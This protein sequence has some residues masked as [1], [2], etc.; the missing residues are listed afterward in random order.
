MGAFY[1]RCTSSADAVDK[2]DKLKCGNAFDESVGEIIS[3]RPPAFSL[4]MLNFQ[5][6]EML[7]NKTKR[8]SKDLANV[9]REMVEVYA[10][11]CKLC[12]ASLQAGWAA[13]SHTKNDSSALV[14]KLHVKH[15]EWTRR[16]AIAGQHHSRR[17][18]TLVVA[19][20][21]DLQNCCDVCSPRSCRHISNYL[22]F[23]SLQGRH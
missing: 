3:F 9:E 18:R 6:E 22:R 2:E 14:V 23:W 17:H 5:K 20:F 16:Q 4:S 10:A 12:V 7:R 1:E 11:R 13:I 19:M 15:M 8:G 21:V